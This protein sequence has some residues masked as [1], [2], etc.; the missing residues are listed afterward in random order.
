MK[1]TITS[2]A[3]VIAV[4][5]AITSLSCASAEGGDG[6]VA[7]SIAGVSLTEAI[8]QTAGQ[9]VEGL[10]PRT[11]VAVAALYSE[12]DN[13]SHFIMEELAGGLVNR[14][15][16][17][18]D[19]QNLPF[20]FEQL[21]MR[22]TAD[23]SDENTQSIGQIMGAHVV[24]T[25]QLWDLGNTRRLTTSATHV[26]TALRESASHFDI[27][28]D[29]AMQSMVA[30]LNAQTLA[31]ISSRFGVNDVTSPQTAGTHLDRALMYAGRGDLD[32]A[33]R[34]AAEAAR[35]DPEMTSAYHLRGLAAA[36]AGNQELA[37]SEYR[38][39]LMIAFGSVLSDF[40]VETNPRY[41]LELD[42]AVE[43]VNPKGRFAFARLELRANLR[44]AYTGVVAI[45]FDTIQREGH[46]DFARAQARVFR[47]A[48]NAINEGFRAMVSDW[49]Q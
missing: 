24:I 11:R 1:K 38:Q 36:T 5:F 9:I 40:G 37:L 10:A 33:A 28:N 46:V 47:L 35:L 15:M 25:G 8:D 21:R 42:M 12:S 16:E 39:A 44:N 34:E 43:D 18:A 30:S 4:V 49:V 22:P 26:Q 7:E 6:L 2:I 48:E 13:L 3:S 32:S 31:Q 45:S 27:P 14:G 23:I 19:R 41:T 29:S 17:V 20:V